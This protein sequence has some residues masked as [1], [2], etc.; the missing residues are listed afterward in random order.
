MRKIKLKLKEIKYLKKD[1][2]IN[3]NLKSFR[4]SSNN[5]MNSIDSLLPKMINRN[6]TNSKKNLLNDNNKHQIKLN[7]NTIIQK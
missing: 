3:D 7:K 2:N 5:I 4:L 6:R 1:L